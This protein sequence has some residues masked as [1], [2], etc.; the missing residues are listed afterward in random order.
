MS[1]TTNLSPFRVLNGDST[2][3]NL[4]K[5][6]SPD[7]AIQLESLTAIGSG[8]GDYVGWRFQPAASD[9]GMWNH[10]AQS[11]RTLVQLASFT[12]YDSTTARTDKSLM[13][14]TRGADSGSFNF[15][16]DAVFWFKAGSTTAYSGVRLY[17][18]HSGNVPTD[19]TNT[20][21]NFAALI[22]TEATS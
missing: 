8:I 2:T 3:K 18:A 11:W 19:A 12:C 15:G 9:R 13:S 22:F 10:C 4:Y 16:D 21:S 17:S 7:Q 6:D 1:Y 20:D 5:L 14:T